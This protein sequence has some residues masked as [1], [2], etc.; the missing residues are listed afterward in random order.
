MTIKP[1][2]VNPIMTI[3]NTH[4]IAPDTLSVRNDM[5]WVVFVPVNDQANRAT[6]SDVHLQI[7]RPT[8]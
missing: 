4:V 3:P 8:A 5:T 2:D 6:A 7:P 1:N